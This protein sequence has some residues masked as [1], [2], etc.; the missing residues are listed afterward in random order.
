MYCVK[1]SPNSNTVYHYINDRYDNKF[2]CLCGKTFNKEDVKLYKIRSQLSV[3][4]IFGCQKCYDKLEV[5]W[6]QSVKIR[7]E[8]YERFELEFKKDK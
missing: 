7:I 1:I 5:F 3:K 4:E 8:N 6:R 2:F